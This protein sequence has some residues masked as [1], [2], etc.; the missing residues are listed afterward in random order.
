MCRI[1]NW[2]SVW[3]SWFTKTTNCWFRPR[4]ISNRMQSYRK[5]WNNTRAVCS[6]WNCRTFI[7]IRRWQRR[8]WRG[9]L[10][11]MT[12]KSNISK[13]SRKWTEISTDCRLKPRRWNSNCSLTRSKAF[14]TSRK[15]CNMRT[16]SNNCCK[17]W[18]SS[19]RST[20]MK[21]I[22]CMATTDNSW[23]RART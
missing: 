9:K 21:W 11:W 2:G 18:N 16:D 7:C 19:R 23:I 22:H 5:A 13:R 17:K 3:V 1:L 15:V 10:S 12:W 8:Y 6:S 4:M 20:L 14:Q